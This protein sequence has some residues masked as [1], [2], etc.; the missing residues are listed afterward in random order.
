M[1]TIDESGAGMADS[2]INSTHA[3]GSGNLG[4]DGGH[5]TAEAASGDDA[6]RGNLDGST[7]VNE[8]RDRALDEAGGN[9]SFDHADASDAAD[10]RD[11][12]DAGTPRPDG[13]VS[14][15]GESGQDNGLAE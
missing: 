3:D 10:S 11:S 1:S 13:S 7:A 5:S 6:A 4:Q 9:G 14:D 15:A 12:G 2:D 8:P